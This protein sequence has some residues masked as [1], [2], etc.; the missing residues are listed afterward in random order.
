MNTTLRIISDMAL[1]INNDITAESH[2]RLWDLFRSL[3]SDLEFDSQTS[4]S[5]H[6]SLEQLE[7]WLSHASAQINQGREKPHF[8]SAQVAL[9][10]IQSSIERRTIG[11]D[12]YPLR[13]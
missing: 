1:I 3:S 9:S 12:G 6:D 13:S 5:E 4:Q 2:S 11:V 7:R 10:G 8:G